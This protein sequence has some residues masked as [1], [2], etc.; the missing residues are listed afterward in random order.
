MTINSLKTFG[1]VKSHNGR[2]TVITDVE[3]RHGRYVYH[4]VLGLNYKK[5]DFAIKKAE[6]FVKGCYKNFTNFQDNQVVF[7]FKNM[8]LIV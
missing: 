5:Y 8:G 3:F 4:S 2:F 1:V 6:S 7:S